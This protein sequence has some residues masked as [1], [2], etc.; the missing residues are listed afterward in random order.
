[1]KTFDPTLYSIGATL[2]VVAIAA[3]VVLSGTNLG[4][5]TSIPGC[6]VGSGCD[7]VTNGPWGKV[8]GI[9]LP[10]SFVGLAWFVGLL[11]VFHCCVANAY[12]PRGFFW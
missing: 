9:V 5:F 7:A 4:V 10:V 1:M 12:T 6:G 8:P 2:L 3:C 11:S